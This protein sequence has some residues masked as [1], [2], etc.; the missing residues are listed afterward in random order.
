MSGDWQKLHRVRGVSSD[1]PENH[2]VP[3]LIHKTKT[4]APKMKVQ[5]HRTGLT[6]EEHLSDRCATT[7]SEDFEEEDT[8][9]DRKACV[10]TK[11]VC[12]R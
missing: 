11:K 3:W 9:R 7:Q 2:Y 1:S 10:E 5:Q 6:G 12:G 8:R 4:K